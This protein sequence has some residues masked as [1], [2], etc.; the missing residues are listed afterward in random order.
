MTTNLTTDMKLCES[1]NISLESG[2][3]T[4]VVAPY[5]TQ[6]EVVTENVDQIITDTIN[7]TPK[8]IIHL[9]AVDQNVVNENLDENIVNE[10]LDENVVNGNLDNL[11]ITRPKRNTNLPSRYD[12]FEM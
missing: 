12:G 9:Q 5:L 7:N 4:T 11:N 10:N 8:A 1:L 6:E 3:E 2:V